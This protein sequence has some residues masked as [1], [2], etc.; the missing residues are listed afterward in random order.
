MEHVVL[1]KWKED[2]SEAAIADIGAGLVAMRD[3]IPG[4]V[5]LAYGQDFTINRAK[6]FTHMLIVRL[7]GRD[8]LPGYAE[9]PE[10]QKVLVKIRE[11]AADIM[12]M[13]FESPRFAP[14]A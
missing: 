3:K 8:M 12:A 1:F 13:D 10:H 6:G 4:V 2:A 7:T 9:H 5:D 11:I 14:S